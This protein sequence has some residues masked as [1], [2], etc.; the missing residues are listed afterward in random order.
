[1]TTQGNTRA[2][3][4]ARMRRAEKLAASLPFAA[5]ILKFYRHVA[6]LQGDVYAELASSGSLAA[7]GFKSPSGGTDLVARGEPDL[8]QIL[9]H[10][11]GFLALVEENGPGN[12]VA[13]SKVV[14]GLPAE[15]WMA[16]LSAYWKTAGV[17]DQAIGAFAQFFARAVMQPCAEIAGERVVAPPQ[18]VTRNT[19]PRCEGRPLLGVLRVEGDGGKRFL[20]CSFCLQEWEFRRILCP[21]CGETAEQKLPVY[22]AEQ[23]PHVR[24]EACDTCKLYLRT[25]DLT[26]DGHAVPIVDD[27]AA[28]PL[29]LWA[30]EHGY[31]RLQPNLLGT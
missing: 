27:L 16:A 17:S 6:A 15:S 31:S 10:Y 5:E 28:L 20:L 19:C 7:T 14:G 30:Q 18:V 13:A 22:V 26:E 25:I 4:E 23:M 12:L 2:P 9:P 21:T 24:V 11:R 3:Y 8:T 1:M 29:T